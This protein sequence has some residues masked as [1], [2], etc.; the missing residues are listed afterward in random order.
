MGPLG[1]I[2]GVIQDV[3]VGFGYRPGHALAWL[4]AVLT[5]ATV[6]FDQVGPLPRATPSTG[7]AW[8]PFLYTLDI[9]IPLLSLG[10]DTAWNPTGWAKAVTVM[11]MVTG[12]V[13]VTTVIAGVGRALK[14]Q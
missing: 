12:W 2:W 3:T 6:Y 13:L 7:P 5:A 8:D 9:L 4:V 10:H 11:L 1:S 14:R